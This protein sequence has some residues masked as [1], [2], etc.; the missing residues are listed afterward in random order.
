MP[1]GHGRLGGLE[2]RIGER[3]R[4]RPAT[5]SSAF[6]FVRGPGQGR[7]ELLEVGGDEVLGD[8]E[9]VLEFDDEFLGVER[10][11]GSV[12]PP[13]D[14]GFVDDPVFERQHPR[15]KCV[16]AG[17]VDVQFPGLVVTI[18]RGGSPVRMCVAIR[19]GSPAR[20]D[21]HRMD[22]SF[23]GEFGQ[24]FGDEV[25]LYDGERIGV[26]MDVWRRRRCC[27]PAHS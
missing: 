23:V 26:E 16:P 10:N 9:C 11:L 6:E 18:R 20:T 21:A 1:F 22:E 27:S 5:G 3:T 19:G 7:C 2:V 25:A 4:I 17:S 13:G 12:A 24:G 14:A 8:G 15:G